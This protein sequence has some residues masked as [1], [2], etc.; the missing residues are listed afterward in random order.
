MEGISLNLNLLINKIKNE[1]EVFEREINNLKIYLG[2][3]G[4][5]G[6]RGSGR[7]SSSG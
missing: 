2:K 3:G 4:S 5:G 6:G 1:N 7:E